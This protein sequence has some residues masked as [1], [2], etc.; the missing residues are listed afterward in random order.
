M[1]ADFLELIAGVGIEGN[2]ATGRIGQRGAVIGPPGV[3][4]VVVGDAGAIPSLGPA[5][6]GGDQGQ[7]QRQHEGQQGSETHG[8]KSRRDA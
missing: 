1:E 7:A 8:E 5:G 3:D 4:D 2:R 6:A